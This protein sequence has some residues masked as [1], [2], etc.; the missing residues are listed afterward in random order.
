M[1]LDNQV[2]ILVFHILKAD[3]TENARIVDQ[4]VNPSKLLDG[5]LDD[6]L[7][8]FDAVVIGNCVSTC[9]SD[10]IDNNVGGLEE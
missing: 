5:S 10:H 3:I 7:S 1:N 6:V 9:S 4:D 8:I 2:P